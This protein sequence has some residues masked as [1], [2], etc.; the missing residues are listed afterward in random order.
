[1]PGEPFAL[2]VESL[3]EAWIERRW[4]KTF[5]SS[6][7]FGSQYQLLLTLHHWASEA[8]AD[9]RK[10]YGET[11]SVTVSARP[12]PDEAPVF[13]VVVAGNFSVMFSLLERRRTESPH[14]SFAV[15]VTSA[16]RA[17]NVVAAGPERH[18]GQWTRARLE[19]LLL[20]VLGAYERSL[21]DEFAR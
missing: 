21:P 7:D 10:V 20:S 12:T 6:H 4:M 5:A 2:R 1:M 18:K 11:L 9:I 8:V 14:W 3:R 15:A 19:D 16:G 13:R 17:G